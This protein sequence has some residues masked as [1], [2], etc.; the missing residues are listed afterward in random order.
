MQT[1][2][3]KITGMKVQE[4]LLLSAW[5]SCLVVSGLGLTCQAK[6][7]NCHTK[8]S[9]LAKTFTEKNEQK[10]KVPLATT[11]QKRPAKI[12]VYLGVDMIIKLF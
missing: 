10:C 1:K 4:A 7:L 2:H 8:K 12:T 6:G 9:T 5:Q 11:L 3:F